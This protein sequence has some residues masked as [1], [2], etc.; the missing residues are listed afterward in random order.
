M[1]KKQL[2]STSLLKKLRLKKSL[3]QLKKS[4]MIRLPR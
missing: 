4:L 1:P 3:M 2:V